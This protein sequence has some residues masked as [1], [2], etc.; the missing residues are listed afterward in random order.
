MIQGMHGLFYTP[1]AEEARAFLR[2][3]LE[4]EFVDAGDGWL[5][6]DVPGAEFGVH[7]SMEDGDTRH[8]ISFWCDDI[9]T[10]VA[11]LRQKGVEF[12]GEIEELGYGLAIYFELPGGVPVQLYEPTH[13]Q[14]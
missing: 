11:E 7:P 9:Q 12:Q 8:K 6:F 4:F 5:I 2:D 3:K 10:T 1:K 13:A 14:P